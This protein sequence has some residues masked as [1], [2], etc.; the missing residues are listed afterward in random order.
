MVMDLMARGVQKEFSFEV[1]ATPRRLAAPGKVKLEAWPRIDGKPA[2]G[3]LAVHARVL[4]GPSLDL[5]AQ[6]DGSFSGVVEIDRPGISI[7]VFGL[8]GKLASGKSIRR[9]AFTVVLLG[10]A[11]D[12]R[13]SLSPDTYEQGQ[14][15][16]V[17]VTL[18]DASFKR[19][20]QIRFGD[21]I[22]VLSFQVESDSF[23][24]ARIRVAPDAF[25]GERTP[26]TYNPQGESLASVHVV[27]GKPGRGVTGKIRCVVFDECGNL[28]GVVL[29]DGTEVP[30]GCRDDK[31]RRIVEA[32]RDQGLSVRVELDG[33]GR[34]KRIEICR[35]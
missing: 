20:S 15:Y 28:V 8:D 16:D 4:G 3:K 21:G 26:V 17:G 13:F 1:K 10:R 30:V 29:T 14:E 35:S 31:L 23:A 2:K 18:F 5:D 11:T 9:V 19:S 22:Q 32:A 34:L 12:P 24:Q 25:V 33:S 27:A 7:I 6:Q